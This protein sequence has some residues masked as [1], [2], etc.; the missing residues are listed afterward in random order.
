MVQKNK[1][2]DNSR[3]KRTVR[4]LQTLVIVLVMLAGVGFLAYPTVANYWNRM[5]Q[6]RS[7][8]TYTAAVSDLDPK[9]YQKMLEDAKDYNRRLALQPFVW[10]ISDEQRAEYS[11]LLDYTGNGIMGFI[12]ID[13]IDVYLPIYHGTSSSV[14]NSSI[15]HLEQTSLPVGAYSYNEAS[16][17]PAAPDGSH[18]A[19]SGHRGLPSARLF[20]DLNMLVVGDIFTVTVLNETYTYQVDQIRETLPNEINWLQIEPGKD[21]CTLI[22]CTPYGVNTHRLLVRGVRVGTD[23]MSLYSYR[24]QANAIL[25]RPVVVAP[26]LALPILPILFALAMLA[27]PRRRPDSEAVLR[28]IDEGEV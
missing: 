1:K 8:M 23:V 25:I 12:T 17:K 7:I 20:S 10:Q 27:P 5:T 9:V 19:L 22:T 16:G 11:S 24:A 4:R 26:L 18:C 2:Q 3:R 28:E 13:K 6:T 15:G 14:L 21:Y